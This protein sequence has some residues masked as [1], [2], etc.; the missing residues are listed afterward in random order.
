MRLLRGL[1][2]KPP[3][4]RAIAALVAGYIRLVHATSRWTMLGEEHVRACRAENAPFLF[5]FWH[6]RMAMLP[7]AWPDRR[8]VRMLI[9]RHADGL[10]IAEV[11][12][13]FGIGTVAG[14]STKG[15]VAAV[16][17]ILRQIESGVC[18]GITPDGPRGP[19]MRAQPGAIA[20]AKRSGAPILP[21]AYSVR[22]RKVLGS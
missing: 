11:I 14:S 16:R 6:G 22:R 10:L 7:P 15:R 3:V 5:C 9:S 20:L 2:R 13:R 4:R 12:R 21:A 19:R 17:E 8:P 18:I 1:H